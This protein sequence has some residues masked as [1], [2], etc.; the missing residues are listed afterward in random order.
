MAHANR[1]DFTG[2]TI[3]IGMDVHRKSWTVS[4]FME[5]IEHKTFT[6]PPDV[7]VLVS[8]LRRHFPGA[9]YRAVYEAGFCGFWIHDKLREQ[10]IPCLVVNPAD[11]PTRDKE[12]ARKGDRNDSRKLARGLRNG[13]LEGIYV[14]PRETVEDR[15]LIRSRQA[16]VR[17][18]TRCKNQIKSLLHFYGIP[19]PDVYGHWSRNFIHSLEALRLERESGNLAMK[20]HLME[21]IH[22]RQILAQLDRDILAL[23]RTDEYRNRVQLLRSVP[24]ISTLS[25]MVLL[26]ELGD[27][28]RFTSLDK[29]CGYVGLT[30]DTHASGEKLGVGDMT[31]RCNPVF[32]SLL[33]ECAWVA[34]RKDPALALAYHNFCKRTLKTKAI[35]KIARKL[36]NRIRFVL[37]NRCQY[38]S[39]LAA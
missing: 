27:L 31:R 17:K 29:L 13:E 22:L 21:L 15:S 12:R 10:G 1:V 36:L 39:S 23:S 35:V 5:L 6:Q 37:N 16:M 7:E 8:Y 33:I 19:V 18:Q 25:A 9:R 2:Q 26:T 20:A 11:I 32:R 4:I 34:V 30:P 38:V 24:G 3:Y 14:P 28:S